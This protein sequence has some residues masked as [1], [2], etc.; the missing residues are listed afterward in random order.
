MCFVGQEAGKEWKQV[1]VKLAF[2][3][4]EILLFIGIKAG[5]QIVS[6]L[7]CCYF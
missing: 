2:K 5:Q 4:N 1:E 6:A 3:T 7:I